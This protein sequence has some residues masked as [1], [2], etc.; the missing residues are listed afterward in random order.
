M[1]LRM[2]PCVTI[3]LEPPSEPLQ[4]RLALT[5][6]RQTYQPRR[7]HFRIA[8]PGFTV[9]GP[10][11]KDRLL[12]FLGFAPQYNSLGRAV[13]FTNT[14]NPSNLGLGL[15]AQHFTQD[16]QTYF[17][18]ARIDAVLTQK[19]RVFGSWLYQY[20][21]ESGDSLP[22]A[23]PITSQAPNP[24]Y[25]NG[26]INSPITQ[27]SHGLGFSNPNATYNVGADITLTPKIV[28]TT[29]SAT[30]SITITTLA[31]LPRV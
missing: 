23:D 21:R 7:D 14:L 10:I 30:S 3:R 9:G 20:Q 26:F 24:G 6:I 28:A 15:G 16:Q 13:D 27:Y 2:P 8:Q 19:I 12:F 5:T 4:R 29:R 31:G 22:G 1:A 18:T 17:S 11:L 25:L